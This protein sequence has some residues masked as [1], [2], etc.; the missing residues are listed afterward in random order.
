MKKIKK[1]I[2]VLRKKVFKP[3]YINCFI[4]EK[5]EKIIK[6]IA[7]FHADDRDKIF[8]F[9][10]EKY[11]GLFSAWQV[12]SEFMELLKVVEDKRPKYVL[13]VGTA[14]GGAFFCFSRLSSEDAVLMSVDLPKGKF[15][16]GYGEWR[17]PFLKAFKKGTQKLFLFREDSHKDSTLIL[18]KEALNGHELDFLFIDGDHTYD[19][20]KKDFE[21]YG[22]LVKKG[23]VI[24]FHDIV[25]GPEEYVGGVPRFWK[26]VKSGNEYKEF[27]EDW[28][29]GS[30]GIGILSN[31]INQRGLK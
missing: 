1:A 7:N 25:N 26:E 20:V 9:I 11:F 21:M 24:G 14:D 23:G 2:K 10:Q 29:Q 19:G 22:P 5:K 28:D 27:I 4:L 30:C 3:I 16:G 8:K 13:E 18:V 31:F 17:V 6:E 12:K 15:G